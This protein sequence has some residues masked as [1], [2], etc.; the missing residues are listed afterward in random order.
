MSNSTPGVATMSI[1]QGLKTLNAA[2]GASAATAEGQTSQAQASKDNIQ[3]DYSGEFQAAAA[4]IQ[5]AWQAMPD[6]S[7]ISENLMLEETP[8]GLNII[9]MDQAGRPMFPE[10][11]RYPFEVT[12]RAIAALAPTLQRL[13]N[14]IEISGHTASGAQYSDPNYGSWELSSDRATTVRQLLGEFGVNDD[15]FKSVDGRSSGD[16]LFPNDP[17]LSGNGRVEIT[18]MHAAPPVPPGFSY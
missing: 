12:R 11:S 2:T 1:D 3:S 4:S 13:P 16:P 17:Y 14:Q 10:G 9:I 18:L 6:I 8:E 15:R 5:Q 7:T